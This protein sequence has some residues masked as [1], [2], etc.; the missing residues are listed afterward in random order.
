[1]EEKRIMAITLADYK[2]LI[3]NTAKL[4]MVEDAMNRFKDSQNAADLIAE[5]EL[6]MKLK[7]EL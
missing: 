6:L 1:M 4:R 7:V 5:L 3:A 2:N